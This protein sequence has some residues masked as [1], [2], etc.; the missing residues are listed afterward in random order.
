MEL[1][2]SGKVCRS[3]SLACVGPATAGGWQGWPE[4]HPRV[5]PKRHP[6]FLL[7]RPETEIPSGKYL[8][9]MSQRQGPAFQPTKRCPLQVCCVSVLPRE[10]A[11]SL[12]QCAQ[13]V[14]TVVSFW[15]GFGILPGCL[16]GQK[17]MSIKYFCPVILTSISPRM[18]HDAFD[19]GAYMGGSALVCLRC[20]SGI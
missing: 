17:K 9:V 2:G 5:T 18:G 10:D 3:R 16:M 7:A 13:Y 1:S 11:V 8:P 20:I 12:P 19:L 4:P 6:C 15:G 14:W